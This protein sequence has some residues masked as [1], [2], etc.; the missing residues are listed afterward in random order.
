MPGSSHSP[1]ST[2]WRDDVTVHTMSLPS[3]AC[4][5]LSHTSTAMPSAS[6]A[7]AANALA[8]FQFRLNT[9]TADS[10]RTSEMASR[11]VRACTPLPSSARVDASSRARSLVAT[12]DTAAVRTAVMEDASSIAASVPVLPSNSSTAPWC[13]SRLVP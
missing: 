8:C 1:N 11:C 4:S 9:R 5:G 3:T 10:G 12:A 13:E 7:Q 2:G 6:P